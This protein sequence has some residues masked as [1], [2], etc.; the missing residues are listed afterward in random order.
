MN[1]SPQANPAVND[2]PIHFEIR[3]PLLKLC[4]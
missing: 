3:L 1:S 2:E 4:G